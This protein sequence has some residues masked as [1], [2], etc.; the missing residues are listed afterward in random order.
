MSEQVHWDIGE[1]ICE[2]KAAQGRVGECQSYNC[3]YH[4]AVRGASKKRR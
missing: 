1:G 3:V 2:S 4:G